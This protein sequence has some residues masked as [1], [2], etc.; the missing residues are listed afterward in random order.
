MG[1]LIAVLFTDSGLLVKLLLYLAI[2]EFTKRLDVLSKF[3]LLLKGF[4]CLSLLFLLLLF[5]IAIVWLFATLW[6]TILKLIMSN[7]QIKL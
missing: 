7:L 6:S 5:K 3:D 4:T 1:G 2:H